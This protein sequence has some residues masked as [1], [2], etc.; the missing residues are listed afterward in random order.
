MASIHSFS[1]MATANALEDLQLKPSPEVVSHL[2]FQ[3]T[4]PLS[5]S[6]TF[7]IL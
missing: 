1:E 4:T 6:L 3:F 5:R 7:Y 2:L